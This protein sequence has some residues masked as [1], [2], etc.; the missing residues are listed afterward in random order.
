[1]RAIVEQM[2]IIGDINCAILP[3]GLISSASRWTRLSSVPTSHLVPGGAAL[4]VSRMN[5]VEPTWSESSQDLVSAFGVRDDESVRVA[6]AELANVLRAK[7]LMHRAKSLP[8][9]DLGGADLLRRQPAQFAVEIPNGDLLRRDIQMPPRGPA[10]E[11]LIGKKQDL[12]AAGERPFQNLRG[13]GGG[14]NQAAV[15]ARKTLS[16]RRRN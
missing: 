15:A 1:M 5:S 16:D 14:A 2:Q 4:T 3:S 11:M 8:E 13:V 10:A 12:F 7:H 9:Q 6:F